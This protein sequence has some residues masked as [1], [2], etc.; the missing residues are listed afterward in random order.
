MKC[1]FPLL[2]GN[3][4]A[5]AG[6]LLMD[7]AFFIYFF[8]CILLGAASCAVKVDAGQQHQQQPS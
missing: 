6:F 1:L 8:Q 5:F 7:F 2:F 3:L 4:Y